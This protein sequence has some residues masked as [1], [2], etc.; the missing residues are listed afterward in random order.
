MTPVTITMAMVDPSPMW[1]PSSISNESSIKGTKV[2]SSIKRSSI[3]IT[4][5]MIQ[6]LLK[7]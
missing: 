3:V 1:R 7:I 5:L 2:K 6:D 4:Y